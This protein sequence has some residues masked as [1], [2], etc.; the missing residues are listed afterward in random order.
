M[1]CETVDDLLLDYVEGELPPEPAEAVRT[2]LAECRR[3]AARCREMRRLLGDLGA[4]RS[5][6]GTSAS[7]APTSAA[8]A[9]ASPVPAADLKRIGDFE[10]IEELGR[11]GMGVVYRARQISLDRVVALKLLS[12]D[13]V[14][15][16]RSIS[17]FM[18]EARAA[19]RLHHTNIVPI[20]AQGREDR[21]VYYAMELIEGPSL[22]EILREQ[23]R[24]ADG[25]VRTAESAPPPELHRCSGA[26]SGTTRSVLRS[27]STIVLGSMI[28]GGRPTRDFKRVARLVAGVA[29]GLHH[30]HEQGVI[31]RDIKPQNLLLGPDEQLHITD[32]GLARV[33]DEPG[34]TRSTEIV[35]T[36]AYMAPEQITGPAAAIDRRTDVYALGVTLYEMLTL[37]R[38]FQ[39]DTYDQ[40]ICRI[41]RREPAPPRKIDP[42]VP[43]DLET[44]CLRA[45]EKE[46]E[47]RFATAAELARDLRR[48]A[49]GFPIVSRPLGPIGKAARW[50]RRHP[51]RASATAAIALLVVALP[52]LTSFVRTAARAE[53][54]EAY[55]VLLNDYRDRE[56]ALARLGWVS[57]I[58]GDS[59]QRGLVEALADIRTDPAASIRRLERLLAQQPKF[60]DAHYLLAW[61]Y[62]RRT[63]TQG[64]SLWADAQ[65]EVRLADALD[66]P[67]T[68]AGYFFRG[69]AVWGL[70]PHEAE[71]SFDQAI[72]LRTNFT[73]AMLHQGRAMNQIMYT[74]R[75]ISYYRK[76]V[77]RLESVALVQPTRAYPRYLLAI[78]HLLAAEIYTAEGRREDA[79]QAYAASLAAAREAQVVESSSPRGYAAEAGYYESRGAYEDAVAA[80]NR[81]DNPAIRKSASDWA[82]R[83]GYEMRLLLWLGRVGEAEAALRQRYGPKCGYDPGRHYDPDESLYAALLAATRGDRAAAARTLHDAAARSALSPE[84]RLLI[85]AGFRLIGEPAPADLLPASIPAEAR[86]S[87]G[88]SSAWTEALAGFACGA[89]SWDALEQA[90]RRGVLRPVDARLR[91]TAAYFFRGVYALAAGRREEALDALRSAAEQRDNENYCFRARLLLVKLRRDPA[92]P[93]RLRGR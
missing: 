14:S 63:V 32:F 30:A 65:R 8:P 46:P 80:W 23:R 92:W 41:L 35:G 88:W 55:A 74:W 36:P 20:Y 82:E 52:L 77:G 16:E 58:G 69:Q 48:Y 39:A 19:A 5:I 2:H 68:A 21:Y 87:P 25:K 9:G 84:A 26:H 43:P 75:D 44:I 56:R 38:P 62:A 76:A 34:L 66:T 59:A 12:A 89:L 50:V 54:H 33:L 42:H 78:T 3:C 17:R 13:L 91:M 37:R 61:A 51:W 11:G 4:A 72:R 73:Q 90:A 57:R 81:L 27:A 64:T 47:R 6:G 67:A 7:V 18:R 15:G 45:I 53:I 10:I 79:G 83:Y 93:A 1:T 71:R 49:D 85:E 29:E 70:D 40:T 28:R 31:H 86:L 24:Q 60:R 22:D